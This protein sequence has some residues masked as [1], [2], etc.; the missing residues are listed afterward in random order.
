MRNDS[1]ALQLMYQAFQG[2]LRPEHFTD[3]QHCDECAEH[4][5]TLLRR[6]PDTITCQDVGNP[7][8]D[9][10]CFISAAGFRY[11]LAGLAR[12]VFEEP[13]DGRSWYTAQFF[14]HL[15]SDG[16]DNARFRACTTG[17]RNAVATLVGYI[18][19]TRSQQL[20][21]ECIADDAMRAWE[22]WSSGQDS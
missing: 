21:D 9:P 6:T 1:T 13:T 7:G 3:F 11:Y 16:P 15:I 14:W 20:H 4:D 10:I 12:L 17:Q 19:E 8:W 22:I 18:I 5:D 2:C